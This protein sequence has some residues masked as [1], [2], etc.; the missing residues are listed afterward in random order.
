MSTRDM[1]DTPHDKTCD[2]QLL[3]LGGGERSINQAR[4]QLLSSP[5][6]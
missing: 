2:D 4:A 1:E 5:S 3:K 6:L